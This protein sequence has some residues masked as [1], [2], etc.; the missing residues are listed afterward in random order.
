MQDGEMQPN[1]GNSVIPM[2]GPGEF[3]NHLCALRDFLQEHSIIRKLPGADDFLLASGGRSGYYCD[4]KATLLSPEGSELTGKVLSYILK[5]EGAEAVG[6]L[7][8][9]AT[10]IAT[11]VALVSGQQGHPIYGFTVRDQ[12]KTHGNKERIAA[13]FHPDGQELLCPNRRVVIVDDV[14]TG[15]RS[16]FKAVEAVR[17]KRCKILA[18]IALVDRGGEGKS[19]LTTENLRYYSLFDASEPGDLKVNEDVLNLT[20]FHRLHSA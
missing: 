5:H 6:G 14:V 20:K 2:Y 15:G 8:L 1:A 9:G 16:V 19:F 18:V 7:Q 17:E 3:K 4:S 10:F 12:Q 11:A 13:S